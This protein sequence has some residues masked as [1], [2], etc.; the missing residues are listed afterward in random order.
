MITTIALISA[1]GAFPLLS[2][3][4]G[5]ESRRGFDERRF[6]DERQNLSHADF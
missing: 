1:L 4:F 6:A 2:A 5:A 3:R